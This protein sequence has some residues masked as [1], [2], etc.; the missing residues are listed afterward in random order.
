MQ[1]H[2]PEITKSQLTATFLLLWI[3]NSTNAYHKTCTD[4]K[5]VC[6]IFGNISMTK[7]RY[8]PLLYQQSKTPP[9]PEA[10]WGIRILAV[11]NKFV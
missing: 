11:W 4:N 10:T 3:E 7:V 8:I 2:L 6:T 9:L 1:P 5:D